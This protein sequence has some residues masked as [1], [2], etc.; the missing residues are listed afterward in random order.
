M[1]FPVV[2]IMFQIFLSLPPP[3]FLF[4][5]L[6]VDSAAVPPILHSPNLAISLSLF[7]PGGGLADCS[8][9]QGRRGNGE[10]HR[11]RY[12]WDAGAGGSVEKVFPMVVNGE[13][14]NQRRNVGSWDCEKVGSAV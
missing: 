11:Y 1:L 4:F 14:E 7:P 12:R 5:L 13:S 3:P 2:L 6:A 10:P 8:L 9:S